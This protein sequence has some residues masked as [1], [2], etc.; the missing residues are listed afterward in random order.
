MIIRDF[1][2]KIGKGTVVNVLLKERNERGNMLTY[3]C[4]EEELVIKN[5]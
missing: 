2:A 4:Q 3:F 1:N 5:T